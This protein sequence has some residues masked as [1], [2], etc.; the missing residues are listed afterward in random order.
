ME[1]NPPWKCDACGEPI[2]SVE[3][4]YVEW[5]SKAGSSIE[6][7]AHKL[8]LVHNQSAS[9]RAGQKYACF[10]DRDY[11]Y[12]EK[13]WTVSD[14]PLSTFTGP[15][16]L[17][18]LLENLSY[19]RFAEPEQVLELIKRLFVPNYEKTRL[20]FDAAL[21]GGAFNPGSKPGYYW[22]RDMQAVLHWMNQQEQ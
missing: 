16:G 7:S 6:G 11:W 19:K 20:S 22:Q 14:H 18:T 9:P 13:E 3:D 8:H 15:D 1:V 10:H 5:L 2:L 17:V 4:G 21:A 12:R